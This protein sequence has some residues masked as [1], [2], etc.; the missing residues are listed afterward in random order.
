LVIR[1]PCLYPLFSIETLNR[2][3]KYAYKP[4]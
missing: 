2:K 1:F 3:V 4:A